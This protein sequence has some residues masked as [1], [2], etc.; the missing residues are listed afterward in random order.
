M[1]IIGL[2]TARSGSKRVPGKN[3]NEFLG[4]PLVE[5]TFDSAENS[6]KVNNWILSTDDEKIIE[7]S[8]NYTI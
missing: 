5:W 3:T 8:K 4:K 2:V 7:I 1:K 6:K